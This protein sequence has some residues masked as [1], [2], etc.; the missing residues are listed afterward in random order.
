MILEKDHIRRCA[1]FLFFDPDGVVDDYVIGILK[2]LRPRVE[3]IL[4]ICNGYVNG[5]GREKLKQVSNDI[6]CRANLGLDVGG[7][8]EGLFYI[9]FKKLS[10]YD[11]LIMLNYTFFGPVYPFEEMFDT[12]SKKDV[13][14]WGITKHHR[15]DPDPFGCIPYG[16][17]PEHIQS[18]FLVLRSSLF[19]SY[20]Y[21]DFI[22]N[23]KNPQT[24]TDS[25]VGYEAVF[26]KY[27]ADE[28][29]RWEVYTDTDEYEGY[30]FCP[31]TFYIKELM[32]EKRCPI[33]KRR[34]FFTDYMDFMLNTCGEPSVKML[35]FMR[36]HLDYDENLIWDNILRLENHSEVHRDM[37]FNYALPSWGTGYVPQKGSAVICILAESV[38]RIRWYHRY[39]K[40]IPE[41]A[42]CCVIGDRAACRETVRFLGASALERMKRIEIEQFEYQKA[43]QL[44]AECS[45]GYR[46]TGI[47]LMENTERQQP[48]SNEVSHQYADWENM[49][50]SEEYLANLTEVFENNSRLGMLI[51]PIPDYGFWF[52]K[53]EDGWMGRYEQV[54]ELLNLWEVEANRRRAGEPLVP[55]G[56]S[57]WLRSEMLIEICSWFSKVTEKEFDTETV[58]LALPFAVQSLGAYTGVVYSDRYLPIMITNED[59]KMRTNNQVVFEKYGPNYLKVCVQNIRDGRFREGG[60]Q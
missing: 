45:N 20:Q 21:K 12:M 5:E 40:S 29:F 42:D 30:S 58:L 54:S 3:Y 35:E 7:Y 39:L 2:G 13:D 4:T 31:N 34:S 9:G 51:P 23:M 24:Y 10:E 46:Y 28:G 50:A 37:H 11:E 32:E 15:V 36:K 8:R 33:I 6:Y 1:I 53:M 19:L 25:I 48:Y 43:L 55:V 44:A 17:L 38:K 47:L 59:Y 22:F 18:F 26:T 52:E 57:F 60:N 27:F 41:W 14:F 49:M 16:Y 56:G